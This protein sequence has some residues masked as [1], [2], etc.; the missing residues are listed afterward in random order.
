MGIDLGDLNESLGAFESALS[1]GKVA[2]RIS[3][4][5]VKVVLVALDGTTQDDT[6]VAIAVDL[7]RRLQARLVVTAGMKGELEDELRTRVNRVVQVL[8]SG[9]SH[10]Q[11]EAAF[12]AGATPAR[13][14]LALAAKERAGLIVVSAPYLYEYEGFGDESLSGPI[15]CLL[16]ESP[17]PLLLIREPIEDGDV[18]FSRL[19]MPMTVHTLGLG[20]AAG[21][22]FK[23]LAEG[24]HIELFAVADQQA[25][26]EADAVLGEAAR[27][28]PEELLRAEQSQIGGVVSA[29]QH[30]AARTG[31]DVRVDV[32]VARTLKP[33]L[34][35]IHESP[36]IVALALPR[37]RTS[38][39]FHRVHDLALGSRYP[40]L[41][42]PF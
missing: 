9:E 1:S 11:I 7:A 12:G 5:E 20:E 19:F 14:I 2:I 37:D 32:A 3:E 40:V 27:H 4:P 39:Q 42:A 41:F 16:A 6:C 26:E 13:Q 23:F 15:D 34:D 8:T 24:G 29:L 10:I 35:R 28:T 30:R 31:V 33:V 25:L 36:C 17:V 21:L 22:A 38:G 18:C